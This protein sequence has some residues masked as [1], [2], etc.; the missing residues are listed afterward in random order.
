MPGTQSTSI[1]VLQLLVL[2]SKTPPSWAM[3]LR[4][5]AHL[6]PAGTRDH[7]LM[8]P[9]QGQKTKDACT[10]LSL[11]TEGLPPPRSP[12]TT[13]HF[14]SNSLRTCATLESPVPSLPRPFPSSTTY[15]D[16][17]SPR[18]FFGP[19]FPSASGITL[20]WSPYL[21]FSVCP[22]GPHPKTHS[23]GP[24]DNPRKRTQAPASPSDFYRPFRLR[25]G[26]SGRIPSHRRQHR[27]IQANTVYF[28]T[29][30]HRSG[31]VINFPSCKY[32]PSGNKN[33][34][35]WLY[36]ERVTHKRPKEQLSNLAWEGP[37]LE[38]FN[39]FFIAPY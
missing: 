12:H 2:I 13:F 29:I 27:F 3:G 28:R 24:Q 17:P 19:S 18:S 6:L 32:N 26:H 7:R 15:M 38:K 8:W 16:P 36:K 37:V 33:C 35:S 30:G 14:H 25:I 21:S 5:E 4:Q 22:Q 11:C 10:A 23:L 31:L 39:V 9:S 34:F 20:P 1:T